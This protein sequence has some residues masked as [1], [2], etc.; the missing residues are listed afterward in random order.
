[1]AIPLRLRHGDRELSFLSIMASFGTPLDVAELVIESRFPADP[2]NGAALR[3][4]ATA[5]PPAVG[6]AGSPG[7]H[8]AEEAALTIDPE[9]PLVVAVV[10]AIRG[11]ATLGLLDSGRRRAAWRGSPLGR[12]ACGPG[13]LPR[14]RA[15][16]YAPP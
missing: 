6:D 8:P 9:D 16:G 10:E 1:M 11:G 4:L 14:R 5:G 15:G 13:P 12:T 2:G 7:R 3:E